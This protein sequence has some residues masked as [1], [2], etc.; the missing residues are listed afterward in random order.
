MA[1]QVILRRPQV[2]AATGL[3]RSSIYKLIL[4]NRFPKPVPISEKAVGWL[5]E[6]IAEWQRARIKERD[7]AQ[8]RV[9]RHGS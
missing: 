3:R 8:S 6:E 9:K 5:E 2:E 4:A 7:N 1:V